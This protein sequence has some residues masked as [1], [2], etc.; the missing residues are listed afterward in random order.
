[1]EK[2]DAEKANGAC[3]NKLMAV[4]YNSKTNHA[5]CVVQ[6]SETTTEGGGYQLT[7]WKHREQSEEAYHSLSLLENT[8]PT[9][10]TVYA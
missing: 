2:S 3:S 9:H 4:R 1:V 5:T 10:A 6:F 8:I 7:V